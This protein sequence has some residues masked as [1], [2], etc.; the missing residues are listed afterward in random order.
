MI[1]L[2]WMTDD[3]ARREEKLTKWADGEYNMCLLNIYVFHR[4]H[5]QQTCAGSFEK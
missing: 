1:K 2:A 3:S 4:G 5:L